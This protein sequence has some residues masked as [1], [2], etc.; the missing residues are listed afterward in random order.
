M[1]NSVPISKIFDIEKGTLQSSKNTPG[2]YDF[3]TASAEWKTNDTY[4]HD[5]E[6]LIFA[7]GASG[8][9]GRT[10]YV[11]GKFITSD[12]CFII[13]PKAHLKDKIDLKF[14]Y[15]YFN[16]VRSKLVKETATGTSKLAINQTN[17]LKYKIVFGEIQDQIKLRNIYEAVDKKTKGLLMKIATQ[18]NYVFLLR[19]LILQMAVEGKLVA[20]DETDEPASDLLM[21]VA[22][23]KEKL[24]IDGKIKAAKT[25]IENKFEEKAFELPKGW[26]WC[27]LHEICNVSDG[28]HQTPM[29]TTS[30]MPFISAQNVKPFKFLSLN[31][32]LVS[33]EDYEM[34]I[35]TNKP[36]PGDILMSRVGAGI[37]E[38]AIVDVDLDFA[39]YVS[40]SLIHPFSCELSMKY[41]TIYLNSP[42]GRKHSAEKTLGKGASQGNLNLDF[43]RKMPVPI[44]PLAEQNRIVEKV[45]QLMTMC[46]DLEESI[47]TSKINA[48]LLM[49]AVLNQ[50]ITKKEK[51][52]VLQ[53][54]PAVSNDYVEQW[55]IAAREDGDIKPETSQKIEAI[56]AK[57]GKAQK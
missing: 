22:H 16:S 40:V 43:I 30:G 4:S 25:S 28:T 7:M 18:E 37:G 17:F 50:A 41:L 45:D 27:R 21:R 19:Q 36:M 3:I 35:K 23:E 6:A 13:T 52:N 11:N 5:C 53:F 46:D 51:H 24:I 48:E 38:A 9:L 44:P 56:L 26:S 10:H 47:S 39:I 15:Y 54:V 49:Q 55:D 1:F 42:F 2:K 33:V 34:Y 8:S 29:Y 57:V 14:Y 32:R 20:H 12:L 31:Y